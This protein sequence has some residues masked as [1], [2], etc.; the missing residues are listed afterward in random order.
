MGPMVQLPIFNNEQIRPY[1]S[2]AIRIFHGLNR[3]GFKGTHLVERVFNELGNKYKADVSFLI[4]GKLPFTQYTKLISQQDVIVDQLFSQ[5]LGIN[6]LLTLAQ[7]KVLVAGDPRPTYDILNFPVPPMI[8]TEPSIIGLKRSVEYLIENKHKFA[9]Y[10]EEGL[11]YVK[12]YHAP[13]VVA[14]KFIDV[15]G[16]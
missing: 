16:W 13:E 3:Y 1:S 6:G 15:F 5:C 14:R 12:K 11:K 8:N 4:K 2:G 9:E 7:G 10:Q